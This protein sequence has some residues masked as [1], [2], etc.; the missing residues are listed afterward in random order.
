MQQMSDYNRG[1][2]GGGGGGGGM[3]MPPIVWLFQ[4]F[5][6]CLRACPCLTYCSVACVVGFLLQKLL[7]GRVDRV[8]VFY[9]PTLRAGEVWR[10]LTYPVLHS[11]LGHLV[12]NM[13]HLLNTLDLEGVLV[14]TNYPKDYS[15]GF[16]HTACLVALA[17]GYAA[18]LGS[19]QN[20]GA[21]FQGISA[22]CFGLDGAL[23]C[24]CGLLLGASNNDQLMQ[25]I[26]VRG[27]YAIMHIA[28]D[29]IQGCSTPQGQGTIG[30]LS[31]LVGFFVGLAYVPLVEPPL[32]GRP[33][34]KTFCKFGTDKYKECFA[35]YYPEYAAPVDLVRFSVI[36]LLVLGVVLAWVNTFIVNRGVH[37]S[38]DGYSVFVK[39][40]PRPE[41]AQQQGVQME[42]ALAQRLRAV[43]EEAQR[44]A[45]PPPAGAP[46]GGN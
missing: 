10:L 22:V 34:P 39:P 3:L 11:D 4:D 15:L 42:Q 36:G 8:L 29:I 38:A 30:N 9:P 16:D 35:F 28:I 5:E 32:N 46:A 12:V 17:S 20:F 40:P 19:V 14:G 13:L 21:M 23:F 18:L 27:L 37:P 24:S 45:V 7:A 41:G 2:G 44:N 26:K 31:H 33:V 1:R 25:F 6:G 43:M